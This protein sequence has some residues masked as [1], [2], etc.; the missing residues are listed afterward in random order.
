MPRFLR[1]LPFP[2]PL[3]IEDRFPPFP[4][5]LLDDLPFLLLE[6]PRLPIGRLL[7]EPRLPMGRIL[8]LRMLFPI[9]K[10]L[11]S[12]Q[13]PEQDRTCTLPKHR[14]PL[15]QSRFLLQDSSGH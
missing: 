2:I 3:L 11:L 15:G 6:E 1:L 12:R 8:I 7:E 10:M 13:I 14:W 9:P 5:S 4:E